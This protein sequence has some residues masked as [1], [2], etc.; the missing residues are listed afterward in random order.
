[1]KYLRIPHPH[2]SDE[3]KTLSTGNA[4][5]LYS[6]YIQFESL[7]VYGLP[8]LTSELI[9][10]SRQTD[11][12]VVPSNRPRQTFW[13][14]SRRW[15]T[16][17]E[18]VLGF[19]EMEGE[20]MQQRNDPGLL[21]PWLYSV[22]GEVPISQAC[23]GIRWVTYDVWDRTGCFKWEVTGALPT[24]SNISKLTLYGL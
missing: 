13:S 5:V 20:D 11:S 6:G 1:M 24:I 4:V 17:E 16:V 18:R 7:P 12:G 14:S 9:C 8:W 22:R 2:A 23:G 21:L 3:N 10:L 19:N 15:D